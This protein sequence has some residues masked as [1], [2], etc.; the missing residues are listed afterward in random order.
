MM[1]TFTKAKAP[2]A[3]T[4]SG[5]GSIRAFLSQ[6]HVVSCGILQKVDFGLPRAEF[7]TRVDLDLEVSRSFR[8]T[9]H[10]KFLAEFR[11]VVL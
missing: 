4:L 1:Y 9:P 2:R 3:C 5:L 8:P 11:A 7:S 10:K 6:A